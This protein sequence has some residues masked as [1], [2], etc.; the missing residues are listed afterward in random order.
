MKHSRCSKKH[1]IEGYV[2]PVEPNTT[3]LSLWSLHG[4]GWELSMRFEVLKEL[5]L[6]LVTRVQP[7]QQFV[8]VAWYAGDGKQAVVYMHVLRNTVAHAHSKHVWRVT[9][10][11]AVCDRHVHYVFERIS[12]LACI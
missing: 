12:R 9:F 11:V 1:L 6:F 10:A 7:L 8:T 2:E 5:V 3:W 4:A